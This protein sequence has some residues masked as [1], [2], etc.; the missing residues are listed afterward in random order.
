[1]KKTNDPTKPITILAIQLGKER[2]FAR[3]KNQ[4]ITNCMMI[5]KGVTLLSNAMAF[6]ENA[7]E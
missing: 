4:T 1:M 3:A 7:K 2:D 6:N 5:L